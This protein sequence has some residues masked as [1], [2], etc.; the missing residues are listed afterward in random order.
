[1]K[2][3]KNWTFNNKEVASNFDTHVRQQLPFYDMLSELVC[4]VA[5][6]YLPRGAVVYDIGSST[7]NLGCR[8]ET[9]IIERD[10]EWIGIDNSYEMEKVYR[11]KGQFIVAD[12][13]TYDYK[14]FNLAIC[15]LTMMFFEYDKRLSWLY[16]ML[17]MTKDGGAI[18]IVDKQES[19][20]GILSTA[21]NRYVF[22]CKVKSG[23]TEKDI[24]DKEFSLCGIQRPIPRYFFK[25][26]N[27]VEIFRFGDFAGWVIEKRRKI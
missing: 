13:L 3:P 2:I 26:L 27:A 18:I 1:M 10:I 8:L 6:H 9:T 12:A 11:A 14:P 23:A 17:D 19:R 24:L 25:N 20:G 21:L 15:F 5:K 4:I 16:K 7:G 22:K